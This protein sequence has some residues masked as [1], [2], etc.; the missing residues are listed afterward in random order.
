[1]K[2]YVA[3][4][5][6]SIRLILRATSELAERVGDPNLRGFD[7]ATRFAV[8]DTTSILERHAVL[9]E[10]PPSKTDPTLA[11]DGNKGP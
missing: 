5:P 9:V 6:E 1:M 10:F 3:V 8:I 4:N 2:N 11:L 7:A